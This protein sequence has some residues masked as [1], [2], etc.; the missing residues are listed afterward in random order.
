MLR[1]VAGHQISSAFMRAR[2][3][4]EY[5]GGSE[6]ATLDQK[7]EEAKPTATERPDR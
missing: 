3:S 2:G 1:D 7:I 6:K 5:N 4:T